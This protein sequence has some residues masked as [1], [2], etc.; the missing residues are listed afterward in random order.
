MNTACWQDHCLNEALNVQDDGFVRLNI[1]AYAA[2]TKHEGFTK[3]AWKLRAAPRR[4]PVFWRNQLCPF[5]ECNQW[6]KVCT[7]NLR[8]ETRKSTFRSASTTNAA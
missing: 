1:R 5:L 2:C 6:A 8:Y 4:N 3:R 7:W